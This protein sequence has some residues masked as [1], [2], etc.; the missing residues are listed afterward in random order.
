MYIFFPMFYVV[1]LFFSTFLEFL[2][3]SRFPFELIYFLSLYFYFVTKCTQ[4]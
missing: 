1:F 2:L 4:K 3:D